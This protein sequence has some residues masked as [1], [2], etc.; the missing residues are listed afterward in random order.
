[1]YVGSSAIVKRRDRRFRHIKDIDKQGIVIAVTENE[2]GHRYAKAEIE[3]AEVV[4]YSQRDQSVTFSKVLEEKFLKYTS[5][6][7][8]LSFCF[9][10]LSITAKP[11][12][13]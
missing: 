9:P 13:K 6:V 2:S 3:N 12:K 10:W 7:Q 1:M 4:V 5:E 11:V 8:T